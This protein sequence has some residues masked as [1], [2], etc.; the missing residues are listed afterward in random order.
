MNLTEL[1]NIAEQIGIVTFAF[2]GVA[3]GIKAKMDIFGIMVLGFVTALGGGL[4]RDVLLNDVPIALTSN[5][6]FILTLISTG[7]AITLLPLKVSIG[8][9][10]IHAA[11][12]IGQVPLLSPVW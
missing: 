10:A 1:V 4:I 8:N 2:S 9:S 7:F 6:Y 3:V 11:D 12:A 5:L